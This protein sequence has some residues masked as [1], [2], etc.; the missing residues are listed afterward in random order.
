MNLHGLVEIIRKNGAGASDW[1]VALACYSQSQDG[2]WQEVDARESITT[3][4]VD[5]QSK[6]VLLVMD[7]TRPPLTV[8]SLEKRLS[9]LTRCHGE[10]MVDACE[11]LMAAAGGCSIRADFPIAGVGR[12]DERSCFLVVFVPTMK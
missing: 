5:T 2:E 4:E 1:P 12:D 11:P 3:V 7:P 6:E 9:E 8:S 10:F